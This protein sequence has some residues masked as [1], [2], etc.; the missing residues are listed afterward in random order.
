MEK[1][2]LT[3]QEVKEYIEYPN[4]CPFCKSENLDADPID[5]YETNTASRN[6]SCEDCGEEWVEE[7]TMTNIYQRRSIFEI[8]G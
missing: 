7:F 6:V 3:E 1:K 4:T 2:Q 8:G 5:V